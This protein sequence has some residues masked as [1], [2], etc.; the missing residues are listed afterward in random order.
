MTRDLLR[1]LLALS[2]FLLAAC[3][4]AETPD[5]SGPAA[6]DA[7]GDGWDEDAD[8]DDQDRFVHPDASETCN[9]VDDDCDGD[10]DEDVTHTYWA[11]ADA[12]GFGD[13][14]VTTEACSLPSGYASNDEDCDDGDATVRPSAE[15]VCDGVDNDCND[16]VDDGLATETYYTDADADGWGWAG[17]PVEACA[18][19]DGTSTNDFDCDDGDPAVHPGATEICNG[20][21]D[22]CDTHVDEGTL[23]TVYQDADADGWGTSK[24]TSEACGASEGWALL[25]GDCDDTNPLVSPD[26]VETCDGVDEDCDGTVDEEPADGSTFYADAD[27]DGYGDPDS[28]RTACDTPP[29]GYVADSTDCDDANSWVHPDASEWCDGVD[30]DCNGEVDDDVVTAEWFRDADGDGYGDPADSVTD[31]WA[32]DGYVDDA[33]DCD[34]DESTVYPGAEEICDGLDNDCDGEGDPDSC[35]L[36]SDLS[37]LTYCD[38]YSSSSDGYGNQAA[39]DLSAT[40]VATDTGSAFASYYDDATWDIIIIDVSANDIPSEVSSRITTQI[41]SGGIVLFS[42][43]DL[44]G[45]TSLQSTLDVTVVRSFSTPL[46]LYP[47]SGATLW[48]LY[49]SL[50]ESIASTSDDWLDNGDVVESAGSTESETLA[51]FD[52]TGSEAS[53]VATYAGQVLVNGFL[54]LDFDGAD[55]DDDGLYDMRELFANEIIWTTGCAP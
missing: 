33:T 19:P 41:D 11:D 24:V 8:C 49:E 21:D 14:A 1:S 30:N 5:D 32:P 12:D 7:D 23:I 27:G 25:P 34:D 28:T 6:V 20:M 16:L 2:P 40:A 46:P 29:S 47:N 54:P 9:G 36:C 44:D 4:A 15:E 22:D 26:G 37:V 35:L 18:Q 17:S 3:D 52:A 39:D 38:G 31:C 50:P 45:D 13:P 10:V 55:D 48:D 53:V 43:W 42:Y 51:Y